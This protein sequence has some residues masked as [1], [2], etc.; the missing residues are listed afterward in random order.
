MSSFP[1]HITPLPFSLLSSFPFHS[2]FLKIFPSPFL[3]LLFFPS[4]S[5]SSYSLFL[6][7]LFLPLLLLVFLFS[8]SSNCSLYHL[9]L[10]IFSLYSYSISSPFFFSY[11]SSSPTLPF[12]LLLLFLLL[13]FRVRTRTIMHSGTQ[14]VRPN[15][16]TKRSHSQ[17]S[18]GYSAGQHILTEPD[19]SSQLPSSHTNPLIGQLELINYIFVL[20]LRRNCLYSIK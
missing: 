16:L 17:A 19:D 14:R 12:L 2:S 18:D 13:L 6:C 1:F 11:Y 4:S 8:S 10:F 15:K 9:L 5:S 20:F 3:L 7:F